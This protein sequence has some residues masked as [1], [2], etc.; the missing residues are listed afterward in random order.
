MEAILNWPRTKSIKI[1]SRTVH[2]RKES[3]AGVPETPRKLWVLCW[4]KRRLF[5]SEKCNQSNEGNFSRELERE[6][7]YEVG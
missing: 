2:T 7:K 1:H 3:I 4:I 6:R 5:C